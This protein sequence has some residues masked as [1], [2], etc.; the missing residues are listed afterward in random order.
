MCIRDRANIALVKD[1]SGALTLSGANK[2]AG[3]TTITGGTLIAGGT[4]AFG[5]GAVA[6]GNG[7]ILDLAS[8]AVTNTLSNHGGT[9]IHADAFTGNQTLDGTS[10]Y[11][12]SVG[13][14]LQVAAG[15]VVKGDGA[16]F[17]GPANFDAGAIHAPGNSPGLQSFGGGL[18]YAAGSHLEWELVANTAALADRGTL[19]DAIDVF[20]G[21]LSVDPASLLDLVFNSAGSTVDWSDTFW[22]VQHSWLLIDASSAGTSTGIFSLGSVGTDSTGA[23]LASVRPNATLTVARN[24]SNLLVEYGVVAVPEPGTISLAAIGAAVAV[25]GALRQRKSRSRRQG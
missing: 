24:G 23:A 22:S 1:G 18:G 20:T 13:G 25:I 14:A 2:Y 11:T 12:G 15:G 9:L 6:L 4:S 5:T 17:I 10:S 3:G 8:L 21:S 16:T 19:Y 7:A